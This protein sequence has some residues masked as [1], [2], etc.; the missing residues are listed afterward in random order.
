MK[1]IALFAFNGDAICFVHVLLNA[2]DMKQKGMDV[3]IV[4]EGSATKLVPEMAKEGNPLHAHYMK[5]KEERLI[6]VA[7]KACS[8]KMNV[9]AEVRDEGIPLADEMFGHPSMARYMNDGYEV[10]VL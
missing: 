8:S 3:K 4:I 7:C 9:L 2:L 10:I 1:K 5:A 6:D